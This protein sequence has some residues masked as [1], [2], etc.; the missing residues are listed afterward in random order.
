MNRG[1]FKRHIAVCPHC[2][3][4]V[5]A[6]HLTYQQWEVVK[7]QIDGKSTK[8]IADELF[9]SV[10]TV[11]AHRLKIWEVLDIKNIAQLIRWANDAGL[12]SLMGW[13]DTKP[14]PLNAEAGR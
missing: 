5:E 10:K 3:R 4:I 14:Q 12:L 13:G 9:V 1:A 6:K 8:E 11:E 7:R 2:R